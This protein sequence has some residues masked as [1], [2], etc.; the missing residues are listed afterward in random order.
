M[1]GPE[2]K[3]DKRMYQPT[4]VR[5]GFELDLSNRGEA[6]IECRLSYRPTD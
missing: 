2:G 4:G 6:S 3:D 5:E 1:P